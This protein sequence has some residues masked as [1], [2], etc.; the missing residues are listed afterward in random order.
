ME[1]GKKFGMQTMEESLLK[2]CRDG[3]IELDEAANRVVDPEA[4]RKRMG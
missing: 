1:I 2:L 4:F 3:I